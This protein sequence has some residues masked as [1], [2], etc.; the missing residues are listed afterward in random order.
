MASDQPLRK[1]DPTEK[2]FDV[3]P[4]IS[5][6]AIEE[7]IRGSKLEVVAVFNATDCLL[8][9]PKAGVEEQVTLTPAE[10]ALIPALCTLTHSHPENYTLSLAD[11][12]VA[13]Q[14]DLKEVR[15]V[16]PQQTFFA[17]RPTRGWPSER[18]IIITYTEAIKTADNVLSRLEE[19][20][21][22]PIGSSKRAE[23]FRQTYNRCV[24]EQLA[25]IGIRTKESNTDTE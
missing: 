10:Q 25:K 2:Y 8:F 21:G 19:R 3:E 20:S 11:V 6:V 18:K 4:S 14:L 24:R 7:L 5:L 9:A 12:L 15:A 17:R 23:L 16:G 13:S 22:K 1:P